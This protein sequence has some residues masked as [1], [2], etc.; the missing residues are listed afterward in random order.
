[1]QMEKAKKRGSKEIVHGPVVEAD[2]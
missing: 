1:M 2:T